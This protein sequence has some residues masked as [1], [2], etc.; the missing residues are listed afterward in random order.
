M[1]SIT[2][3]HYNNII[4]E[5]STEKYSGLSPIVDSHYKPYIENY[6]DIH[7]L[8]YVYFKE[9]ESVYIFYYL[10]SC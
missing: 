4:F 10:L 1:N 3:F 8:N 6:K 9:K 2:M 5:Q 7:N